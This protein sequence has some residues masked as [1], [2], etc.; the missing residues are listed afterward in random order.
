[1]LLFFFFDIMLILTAIEKLAVTV[2]EIKES[3]LEVFCQ[4]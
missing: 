1:M 3:T 2:T 4:K